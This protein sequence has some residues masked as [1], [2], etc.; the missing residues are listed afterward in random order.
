MVL[1]RIWSIWRAGFTEVEFLECVLTVGEDLLVIGAALPD[2]ARKAVATRVKTFILEDGIV[3]EEEERDEEISYT[4]WKNIFGYH[5]WCT[6]SFLAN[7]RETF[8]MN[9]HSPHSCEQN[10]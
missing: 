2:A 10:P 7:E 5:T 1:V 9:Q 8:A 3:F 4:V 6:I